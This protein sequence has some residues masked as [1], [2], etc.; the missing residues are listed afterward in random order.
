MENNEAKQLAQIELCKKIGA[1]LFAPYD[2]RCWR[3]G[4]DVYDYITLEEAK[5]DV[6]TY[7]KYC[8]KSF[9]D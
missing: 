7:C 3:C 6:I 8:N 9:V 2:G 5:T 1:P 4:R